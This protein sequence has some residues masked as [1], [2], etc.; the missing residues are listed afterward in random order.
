MIFDIFIRDTFYG[1]VSFATTLRENRLLRKRGLG[2]LI[3]WDEIICCRYI[4]KDTSNA[5]LRKLL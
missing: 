3:T 1:T 2:S 4:P 5:V